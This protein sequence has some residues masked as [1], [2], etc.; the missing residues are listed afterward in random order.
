MRFLATMP[1]SSGLSSLFREF[2]LS[3]AVEE[4]SALEPRRGRC[5]RPPSST[6]VTD[7]SDDERI[8]LERRSGAPRLP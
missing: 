6:P 8:D 4:G 3:L 5:G 2:I 1:S 7:A